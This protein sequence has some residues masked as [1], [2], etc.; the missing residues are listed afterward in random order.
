MVVARGRNRRMAALAAL[1]VAAGFFVAPN[2]ARADDSSDPPPAAD[3]ST[4]LRLWQSG[5]P[6][7]QPAAE[8]ALTGTDADVAAFL[9]EV[10]ELQAT[11]ERITVT[12]MY[13]EG[14]PVIRAAALKALDDDT[15]ADFLATG[16]QG[17][18]HTDE[19][20]QITRMLDAGGNQVKAAAQK[21]LDADDASPPDPT[22]M[23]A[24]SSGPLDAFL[25]KGWRSADLTDKRIQ[26]TQIYARAAP[27]SNVARVALQALD[28]DSAEAFNDF[29]DSGYAIAASRDQ[30]TSTLAD[31]VAT[32]QQASA[33]V[34][35]S[36]AVAQDQGAKAQT[37]AAEAKKSALA[38]LA[39]MN[40]A[41]NDAVKAAAATR[42]AEAAADA[43]ADAADQAMA[44]SQAA[45]ALSRQAAAAAARA[46]ATAA[47]TRQA[48]ETA[49]K[50]AA[51]AAVEKRK[52][53]VAS[54]AAIAASQAAQQCKQSQAALQQIHKALA[55][56]VV[57][58]AASE[59]ANDDADLAVAAANNALALARKTGINVAAAEAAARHAQERAAQSRRAAQSAI[60]FANAALA[61]S[62]QAVT[63]A[64]D[65]VADALAAA[66][67]AVDA[68]SHAGD[69][70]L[71][72]ATATH[73]ADAATTSADAAVAAANQAYQVYDAARAAESDRIALLSQQGQAAAQANLA[74]YQ[75][76]QATVAGQVDE[77]A[78]RDAET[79]RLI[80]EV[81]DPA[82]APPT[83][84]ADARKVALALAL[85]SGP[86]SQSAAQDALVGD[87]DAVVSYVTTG[88][89]HAA[90][91]DDRV[92]VETL[93]VNGTTGLAKA[94][95]A[96]LNGSDA[97]V[98]QFLHEQNYPGRGTDDRV[99]VTRLLA[100][101][102]AA[103]NTVTVQRAQQALDGDDQA[104]RTFLEKGQFDAS[105]V[106]QQV[107]IDRIISSAPAGSELA[108]T[109]V[110]ALDGPPG[111]WSDFLTSGQY[112]AAIHD[113]NAQEHDQ[114]MLA[115]LEKGLAAATSAQQA[116]QEAQ[117]VAATARGFADIATDWS[118][119]AVVSAQTAQQHAASAIASSQAA[120]AASQAAVNSAN[121]ATV[122]AAKA[123]VAA[124]SADQSARRAAYA[125]DQ[126]SDAAQQA[127][128]AG[129]RARADALAAGKDRIAAETAYNQ[130]VGK[131]NNLVQQENNDRLQQELEECIDQAPPTDSGL[132]NCYTVY[133]PAGERA[134][135]AT[136]NREF[137][138][139]FARQDDEAYRQCVSQTLDPNFTV[140]RQLDFVLGEAEYL[141]ATADVLGG[142]AVLLFSVICGGLCGAALGVGAG[143]EATMGIGGLY[144]AWILEQWSAYASGA[145][146]GGFAGMGL[147]DELDSTLGRIEGSAVAG[148]TVL[149]E[150]ALDE[151]LSELLVTTG[152][153]GNSFLPGTP[154][155]MSDG[156]TKP[157]E[158]IQVGDRVRS[159]DPVSGTTDNEPVTHLIP[160]SGSKNL[161]EI[162]LAGERTHSITATANHPFWVADVKK[163]VPA[164]QLHPGDWLRTSA[165]T[166]VEV[167]ALRQYRASATVHNLTV[168][169]HHTYYVAAGRTAVL[170]HNTPRCPDTALG[171]S[172]PDG[173]TSL[174]S[175][176]QSMG[177]T[178]YT[179]PEFNTETPG[180]WISAVQ[181]DIE[182]YQTNGKNIHV[183]MIGF[184]GVTAQKKFEN[185][186]IDGALHPIDKY[187]QVTGTKA[188][189]AEMSWLARA[190]YRHQRPWST[191]TFYDE[192]GNKVHVDEPDWWN[193][194]AGLDKAT[195]DAYQKFLDR[196]RWADENGL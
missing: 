112:T 36:L 20:V 102:Q 181:L 46:M 82:T 127:A 48:A 64:E 188:T 17:P 58:Q 63:A 87:D 186:V 163:W 80:T 41:K 164:G 1:T 119:K 30:E 170:V 147:V 120:E 2:P 60:K 34:Q 108:V 155:L 194:A 81:R 18:T 19:R 149:P 8:Q 89:D 5:G 49:N 97:D 100:A 121:K 195:R 42:R 117:A 24:S 45:V 109:A 141:Q 55:D 143:P 174:K 99:A 9:A 128:A 145:V 116:A 26:I 68:A 165:G 187:G 129:N 62:D 168:A 118:N 101:A 136:I 94:A 110:N 61:A 138:N 32:A 38:A 176:A 160:G 115:L 131:Y 132:A 74:A 53:D 185:A 47:M 84:V 150:L 190:V 23:D 106:D 142:E 21:A 114:E 175:W 70:T 104:V 105:D 67:N 72:A 182:N 130:E 3:R 51:E 124:K 11:D 6:M 107:Q 137:C 156:S 191:V 28:A 192:D 153:C 86:N 56:T 158:Q 85:S 171:I 98:V 91:Q 95:L 25:A 4:V 133:K 140:N 37:A 83:A 73:A 43:A 161:V 178:D 39:D 52:A 169:E 35:T 79:N 13:A 54:T 173:Y 179:G 172:R 167:G 15:V 139:H 184:D 76:F 151:R 14:G 183:R 78:R 111:T 154:V 125:Y 77:A 126:A 189:Y 12:R 75:S 29:L 159:T 16:W 196:D 135:Q 57:T 44:A 31:L 113:Q 134:E 40:N 146:A 59:A 69:A 162:T 103:G 66:D 71:A 148:R 10:P 27:A 152:A 65:A 33:D 88:I 122:A 193:L 90:A 96:A 92:A 7:V 180:Q 50:R 166:W 123:G 157:I 22:M 93:L 177:F 144:D